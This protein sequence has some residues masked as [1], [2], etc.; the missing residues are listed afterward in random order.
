M[1]L[2]SIIKKDTMEVKDLRVHAMITANELRKMYLEFFQEKSHKALP[3]FSLIPKSDPT[4]LLTGAG[5]VPLK[6]YFLGEAKPESTRMATCQK[7]V[8]TGDIDNVGYTTRHLTFFEMLGNFSFGDYFKKEV[9]PW[10]YEFVTERLKLPKDKLW[11]TV[12]LDDD[13]AFDLWVKQGVPKERIVRLG[14]ETNFWELG[15]G[16]CGPNSE[17][18]VDLGE[19]V[20]CGSPNCGPDCECGRFL[21][22]WNLVFIQ[23]H[24]DA[25]GNYTPL[26]QKG[27]DTGMGLERMCVIMQNVDN[28]FEIDTNRPI[29]DKI[30]NLASTYY[31]ENE[32]KD[33]A[34]RVITDHCRSMT[35]MVADGIMPSN[36]G[37]G[38]V[39]RRIL[40]RAVRFAKLLGIEGAF[41]TDVIDV[42]IEQMK[43]G[44]PE[45]IEKKEHIFKIVSLE[46]KRF[47]S[48]LDLGLN[49]LSNLIDR[50]E[51]QGQKVIPGDEVFKLYDTYGFPRELTEEIASE[52]KFTID[53]D[54]F[55]AALEKQREMARKAHGDNDYVAEDQAFFNS[56]ARDYQS[57]FEGYDATSTEA[58]VTGLVWDNDFV[59]EISH[60]GF[61]ILDKT[62]FYAEKG[63]Q[64]ADTGLI[65]FEGGKAK[66][67]DVRTP[68][69]GLI[70]HLVEV[71]EGSLKVGSKV[72][73]EIDLERR[74]SI[75]RN[76][77]ATHI[78]HKALKEVL[79]DHVN[80]AGSL[81]TPERLRFDFSH[82]EAPT[83]E[84]L[85]QI[86]AIVNAKVRENLPVTVKVM[87]LDEAKDLGATALFE[88][89]YGDKV[90]LVEVKGYSR[91]L[92]GGT[93]LNYTGEI[94]LVK[95]VSEGS[96]A[97]GIRRIEAVTGENAYKEILLLED[98]VN[99]LAHSLKTS[100]AELPQRVE[101]LEEERN[102]LKRTVETLEA[103]IAAM[104][105]HDL[106]NNMLEVAGIAYKAVNL[107][108]T[109]AKKLRTIGDA[110]KDKLQGVL[111]LTGTQEGKVVLLCL[112]SDTYVK[113]G[114]H[115]G[116]LVK[117]L[118]QVVGGSGGG[119]PDS[120]Q[121]GGNNPAKIGEAMNKLEDLI[122]A[123]I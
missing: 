82:Y 83:K 15:I 66:V 69:E 57:T 59:D 12:Y 13:E 49:L 41:L 1:A 26:K 93:H 88:E 120:A 63:G 6:P 103:R 35:F 123:M 9:I 111:L 79:G 101:K 99:S 91:E 75:A 115:A 3:S 121:A 108:E 7:C 98:M 86:E 31:G 107:G 28:V 100:L 84:E 40:R 32:R 25:E 65:T 52:R 50:L 112:V 92:C 64:I 34:L 53:N 113:K 105:S 95:I 24:K 116:K 97:A 29:M 18:F 70:I 42:V 55:I 27:I 114:I 56:I 37:R 77:T 54:G 85:R 71:I 2:V 90:R 47:Q 78:L 104:Q 117:E 30:A 67:L 33:I 96:V 58:V 61:V 109:D 62:P 45:L 21:E 48:T 19:D 68:A 4:L 16:P 102:E 20:G 122:K 106:L 81:V 43:E 22:F 76:H 46:E 80:Q 5:M 39:L 23:F 94:G 118:A 60:K 74:L 89:K 14:K 110:L 38:Y 36:E 17:L 44:Y 8:R 51:A 11:F 87:G 10:A 119:R 72:K 73:A